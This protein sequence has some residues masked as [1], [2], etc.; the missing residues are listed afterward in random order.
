MTTKQVVLSVLGIATLV[1]SAVL[2]YSVFTRPVGGS[3]HDFLKGFDLG[4]VIIGSLVA[5]LFFWEAYKARSPKPQA[6][7]Q[8]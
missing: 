6:K 2:A 7:L 4:Y 5:A 1:A 8:Q 3:N